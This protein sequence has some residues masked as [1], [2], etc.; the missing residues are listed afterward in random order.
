M[1]L[2]RKGSTAYISKAVTDFDRK[3]AYFVHTANH[4]EVL[5]GIVLHGHQE[6][7]SLCSGEVD[8]LGVCGLGP[9]AVNFD[10]SHRMSFNPEVLAGKGTDVGHAEE[11]RL[12]RLHRHC[13]IL[14]IVHESGIRDWFGTSGIL[15][16][17]E[18]VDQPRHLVMIPIRQC[19]GH[20]FVVLS[21][22]WALWIVNDQLPTPTIR[23]LAPRVRMVPIGAGLVDLS[24]VSYIDF[25]AYEERAIP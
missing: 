10:D 3:I 9:D 16:A 25:R 5:R 15:V 24:V 13:K 2:Y 18:V 8:H 12:A 20:L 6:A 21:S 19:D 7:V 22:V 1:G 23:V 11:V 4:G 17:Q 14:G